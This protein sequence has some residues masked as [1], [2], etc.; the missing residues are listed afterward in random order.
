VRDRG[1]LGA[2]ANADRVLSPSATEPEVS[3]HS[4]DAPLRV[5]FVVNIRWGH[6]DRMVRC[7]HARVICHVCGL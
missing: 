7:E 3:A 6:L 4:G 5:P 1:V 2:S